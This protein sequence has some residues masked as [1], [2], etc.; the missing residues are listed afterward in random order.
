MD[1]QAAGPL[2]GSE[3]IKFTKPGTY[4]YFCAIHGRSMSGTV[5]V[6]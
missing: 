4:T 5:V 2:P 3:K 6:H 1:D